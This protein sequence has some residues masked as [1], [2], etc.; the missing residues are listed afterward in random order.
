MI[1]YIKS[2]L[3]RNE[4]YEIETSFNA[5]DYDSQPQQSLEGDTWVDVAMEAATA[6]VETAA[7]IVTVA[8]PVVK[9]VAEASPTV[10]PVATGIVKMN[11]YMKY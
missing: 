11:E 1:I 2:F 5:A 3:S 9:I 8:A 4:K 7:E 10:G 6:V